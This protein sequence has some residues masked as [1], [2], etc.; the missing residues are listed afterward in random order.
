MQQLKMPNKHKRGLCQRGLLVLPMVSSS[1]KVEAGHSFNYV[2]YVQG[3]VFNASIFWI[4]K[5]LDSETAEN[6]T[7]YEWTTELRQDS[8]LVRDNYH[9]D[10][11]TNFTLQ[12]Y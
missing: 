10:R 7:C 9:K 8:S 11:W 4:H 12:I 3:V 1:S 5:T 2:A 6:S